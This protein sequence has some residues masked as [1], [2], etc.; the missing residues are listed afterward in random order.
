MISEKGM[1]VY[2]IIALKG[3]QG[4]GRKLRIVSIFHDLQG[5][6]RSLLGRTFSVGEGN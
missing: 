3:R 4:W 5:F 2:L 6:Q 1:N